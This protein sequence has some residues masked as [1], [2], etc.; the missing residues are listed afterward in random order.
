MS[1]EKKGVLEEAEVVRDR[2]TQRSLGF[3]FV[4]FQS[5]EE[6]AEAMESLN[7][8]KKRASLC[9]PVYI[10]VCVEQVAE[11]NKGAKWNSS[12]LVFLKNHFGLNKR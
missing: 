2:E 7:G 8:K 11:K 9:I 3:G 12:L 6:A 4:K 10:C 5:K 1:A